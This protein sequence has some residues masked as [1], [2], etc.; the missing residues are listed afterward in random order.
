M[1]YSY[2]KNWHN[3]TEEVIK[4]NFDLVHSWI[5][6]GMN[7]ISLTRVSPYSLT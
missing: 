3:Q 1:G 2:D 6:Q 5:F 4:N 7:G